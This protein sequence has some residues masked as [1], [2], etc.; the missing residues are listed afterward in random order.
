MVERGDPSQIE[1]NPVV[2]NEDLKIQYGSSTEWGVRTG[3]MSLRLRGMIVAKIGLLKEQNKK[4]GGG[5]G[6]RMS[7]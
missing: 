1:R 5:G 4:V 3:E 7:L 6:A 2:H